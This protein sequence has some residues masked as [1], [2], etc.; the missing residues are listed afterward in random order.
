MGFIQVL[1]LEWLENV[2]I[3]KKPNGKWR[4]RVD[5]TNL[6]RECPNDSYSLLRINHLVDETSR[7]QLLSFSDAFS[8]YHQIMIYPLD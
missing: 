1:Y 5:F 3:V 6:N 2:V 7:Y 8:G 4:V